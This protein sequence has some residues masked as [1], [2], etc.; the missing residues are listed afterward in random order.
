MKKI[1]KN[2]TK[3]IQAALASA[4]LI[5]VEGKH[6]NIDDSCDWSGESQ[7]TIEQANEFMVEHYS[8]LTIYDF[9]SYLEIRDYPYG[10]WN[11][12]YV[13]FGKLPAIEFTEIQLE[14]TV[15]PKM[16]LKAVQKFLKAGFVSPLNSGVQVEP[17]LDIEDVKKIVSVKVSFAETNVFNDVRDQEITLDTFNARC[18]VA[19]QDQRRYGDASTYGYDKIFVTLTLETGDVIDHRFDLNIKNRTLSND[20]SRW[21]DYCNSKQSVK[22]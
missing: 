1:R 20:W 19:L 13:Y 17:E 16:T 8:N 2:S 22:H 10:A 14:T 11:V 4:T 9:G 15:K 3:K 7:I 21:V 18:W 6:T 5:T 12:V